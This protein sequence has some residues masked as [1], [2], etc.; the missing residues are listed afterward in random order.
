AVQPGTGVEGLPCDQIRVQELDLRDETGQI[1]SANV[2]E[3]R[4]HTLVKT[5]I[6]AGNS[7][8]IHLLDSSKTGLGAPSLDCIVKLQ[9][10]YGRKQVAVVVDA[11]QMRVSRAHLASY[12]RQGFYVIVTGSKF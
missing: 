8:L 11:A 4:L 3:E 5:G 10:A 12:L 2:V 6:E 9:A 7:V 1:L